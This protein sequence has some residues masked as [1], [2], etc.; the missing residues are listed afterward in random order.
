[1]AAALTHQLQLLVET[2]EAA[3]TM[4]HASQISSKRQPQ[5]QA[6][7]QAHKQQVQQQVQRQQ[8]QN[9]KKLKQD[10]KR[11]KQSKQQEQEQQGFGLEAEQLEGVAA[12]E[13]PTGAAGLKSHLS[14]AASQQVRCT[15]RKVWYRGCREGTDKAQHML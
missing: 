5:Q 13:A 10:R 6:Q 12:S 11:A 8:G 7:K 14:E 3:A 9:K 4:N 1:M 15:G 2:A